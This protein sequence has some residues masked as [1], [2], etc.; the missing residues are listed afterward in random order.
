[1]TNQ[2]LDRAVEP[3]VSTNGDGESTATPVREQIGQLVAK[4]PLLAAWNMKFVCDHPASSSDVLEYRRGDQPQAPPLMIKHRNR[5]MNREEGRQQVTAEFSVLQRIWNSADG[6]LRKTIPHPIALLPEAGAEVFEAVRGTPLTTLLRREANRLAGPFCTRRMC[7][8]AGQ[9][10]DWLRSF[11]GLTARP[12]VEHNPAGYLA[13]LSYWLE[14]SERRGLEEGTAKSLWEA[15]I[16]ACSNCGTPPVGVAGV[17]GDFIPQNIF[18]LGDR[19][20]VIDFASFKEQEL[21]YEDLGLFVAYLRLLASERVYSRQTILA[22]ARAFLEAYGV[23][24]PA[25]LLNLYVL[26]AMVMIF[27]DQFASGGARPEESGKVSRIKAQL[28][29]APSE[30]FRVQD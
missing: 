21:V 28:A 5:Q 3:A 20:S 2:A 4:H 17:H 16:R 19:I 22:M 29:Q 6:A 25:S 24:E 13:K 26:K 10:G 27:A 30:L 8:V 9:C 12:M 14:M 7:R 1:M 23:H 15:A 11:H 18:V